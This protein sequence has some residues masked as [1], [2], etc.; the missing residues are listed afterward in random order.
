[1]SNSS[2]MKI[3]EGLQSLDMTRVIEYTKKITE[4]SK[5]AK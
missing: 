4:I 5:G 3:E 1:M 2:L